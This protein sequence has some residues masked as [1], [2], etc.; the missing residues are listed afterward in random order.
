MGFITPNEY[1]DLPSL[2]IGQLQYLLSS[3]TQGVK[4]METMIASARDTQLKQAFQSHMQE[5][6]VQAERLRKILRELTGDEDDKKDPVATALIGSGANITRETSEGSVRDAGLLATQQKIEH[7]EIASYGAA[8]AWAETL[9]HTGHVALL[10]QTLAEEKHADQL[11]TSI[12]TRENVAA[13][14]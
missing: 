6:E 5:T 12:A 8:I 7:Y 14:A 11:L 13:I 2:Y 1:D 9:G 4:G 3:E 10:Q